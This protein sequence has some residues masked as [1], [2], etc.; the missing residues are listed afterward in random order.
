MLVDINDYKLKKLSKAAIE[1]G[2]STRN[3]GFAFA[4]AFFAIAYKAREIASRI[5]ANEKELNKYK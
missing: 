1:I 2:E 4:E 5:E 3:N